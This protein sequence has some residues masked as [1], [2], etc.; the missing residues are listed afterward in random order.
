MNILSTT[1]AMIEGGLTKLA[2]LAAV[3]TF[4]SPAPSA[5]LCAPRSWPRI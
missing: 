2:R 3:G 4:V 5:F 1:E